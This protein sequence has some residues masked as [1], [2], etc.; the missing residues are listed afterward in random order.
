N[1]Q[2]VC[3]LPEDGVSDF[4]KKFEDATA[5][6]SVDDIVVF[7][8]L[9]G[10]TPAN[11]VS[12]LIKAGLNIKLYAGLNM[13]MIMEWLNCQMVDDRVPDYVKAGKD[14]V[15]DVNAFLNTDN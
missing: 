2:A 10:G 13:A 8:D 5:D 7:A 11:T 9:M 14:G 12:R 6:F 4:Q 15:V 1:I 3:M